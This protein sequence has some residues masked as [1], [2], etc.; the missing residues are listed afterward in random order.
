MKFYKQG[1][2][3]AGYCRRC[4]ASVQTTFRCESYTIP[5]TETVVPG[6]LQAF[7]DTCGEIVSL[8]QQSTY[9]IKEYYLEPKTNK[10]EVR[11]PPVLTDVLAAIGY[12]YTKSNRPN[13]LCRVLSE[14]YLRRLPAEAAGPLSKAIDFYLSD[15]LA[16]GAATERISFVVAS[17]SFRVLTAISKATKHTKSDVVKSIILLAKSDILDGNNPKLTKQFEREVA[18]LV[19]PNCV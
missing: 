2:K 19:V 7:C 11:V 15:S 6:V 1:E 9:K 5:E 10:V 8:P 16:R 4:K 17:G 13:L 3:S 12:E 14:F 18:G